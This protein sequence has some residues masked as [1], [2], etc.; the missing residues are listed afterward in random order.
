MEYEF[1]LQAF[2]ILFLSFAFHAKHQARYS[3]IQS[4]SDN[5]LKTI[6]RKTSSIQQY[7]P[8]LRLSLSDY[9]VSAFKILIEPQALPRS[10][11][12]DSFLLPVRENAREVQ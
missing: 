10:A 5:L 1:S 9:L 8:G 4:C 12:S 2:Y 3:N 6:H 7:T 11:I